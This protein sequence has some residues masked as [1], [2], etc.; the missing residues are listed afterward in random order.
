MEK[1]E[2]W[3][4]AYIKDLNI[5]NIEWLKLNSKELD[6]FFREN[7]LDKELW[8]YVYDKDAWILN[9]PPL[10]MHYINFESPRNGESYSFLLGVVNNNI[11]K[12]TIVCAM[13]YIEEYFILVGQEVPVTY[14]SSMEVNSYFWRKG[15]FKRMCNEAINYINP[16]QHII[17][18]EESDMGKMCSTFSIFKNTMYANGFENL[19]WKNDYSGKLLRN[20]EFRSKVLGK[21]KI[22]SKKSTNL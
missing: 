8:E 18:S 13:I 14:I 9:P 21:P 6:E 17:V 11:S 20:E 5:S 12:K 22:K 16:N 4:N 1:L 2:K 10:G 15:L 19:I 7:Y 3:V